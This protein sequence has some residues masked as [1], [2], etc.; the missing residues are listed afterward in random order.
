ML[1]LDVSIFNPSERLKS[2]PKGCDPGQ[3]LLI[4]FGEPMQEHDAAHALTLLRAYCKRPC[5]CR[6]A[7]KP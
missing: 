4:V 5:G 7:E 3:C 2:F 1:D 6:A